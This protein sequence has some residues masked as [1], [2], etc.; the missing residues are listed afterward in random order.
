M[1]TVMQLFSPIV[2]L[3]KTR[4]K[5]QKKVSQMFSIQKKVLYNILK[6]LRNPIRGRPCNTRQCGTIKLTTMDFLN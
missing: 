2:T 3:N 1:G 5:L 4:Y 6:V